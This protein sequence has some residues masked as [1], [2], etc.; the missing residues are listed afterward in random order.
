[1]QGDGKTMGRKDDMKA[2]LER[3]IPAG[4]VPIWEL[5]FHLW[6]KFSKR[7]AIFGEEFTKLTNAEQEKAIRTNAEVIF[8]VSRDLHFS[9]VTVPC[10][11][12]EI[13][14]GQMAY[15]TLPEDARYRQ[16]QALRKDAPK[17]FMLVAIVSA[18]MSI[19]SASEYVEFSYKLF[20]APDEIDQRARDTLKQGLEVARRFADCGVEAICT[21]SDIADNRGPFFNPEQMKRFIL[22]YLHEWAEKIKAMG[23]YAILHSDGNLMPVIDEIADSGIDALQAIDPVAGMDMQKTKDA[24]GGRICLCGNVDCG[25]LVR[26]KP[27]DVFEQT[28]Q[29]LMSCKDGGGFVLGASNAVQQEVPAENYLAMIRA[30]EE[31]GRY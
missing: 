30:W 3:R 31:F 6:N 15:Y 10:G 19:P 8:E 5:E 1:M 14:P 26:G 2:A 29:L 22:P 21:A 11:L 16:V 13:A 27:E 18:V 9:A 24:V 28:K 4:A 25:T 23:L 7:H 17:D 12:W 20:D